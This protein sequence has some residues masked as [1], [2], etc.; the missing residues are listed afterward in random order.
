MSTV[1]DP[2]NSPNTVPL[3][4]DCGAVLVQ[5]I[6]EGPVTHDRFFAGK[7]FEVLRDTGHLRFL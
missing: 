1:V 7:H 5:V 3:S 6:D 4:V 2:E